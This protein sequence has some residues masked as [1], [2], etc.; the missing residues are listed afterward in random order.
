MVAIT[1]AVEC[2][3][4]KNEPYVMAFYLF[5]LARKL[6]HQVRSG[7]SF[8]LAFGS[9]DFAEE[10][11]V[12]D[13]LRTE[14]ELRQSLQILTKE[15]SRVTEMFDCLYRRVMTINPTCP[16]SCAQFRKIFSVLLPAKW[17]DIKIALIFAKRHQIFFPDSGSVNH[18]LAA[19]SIE[20][21]CT[22]SV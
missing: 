1:E 3:R 2:P 13:F 8:P 22:D 14:T 17:I 16:H 20:M 7:V 12:V 11:H 10:N 21:V 15:I 19:L 6:Y 5:C 18:G 9:K 4:A